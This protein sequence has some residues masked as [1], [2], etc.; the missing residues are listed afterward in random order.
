MEGD[1]HNVCNV[2]IELNRVGLLLGHGQSKF[3]IS[4]AKMSQKADNM[5]FLMFSGNF[6]VSTYPENKYA[7]IF[8][9]TQNLIAYV[10]L[11][12]SYKGTAHSLPMIHSYRIF[13][14]D[15]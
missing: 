1:L 5:C 7:Q 8:R 12:D 6:L 2:S 10:E 11:N 13:T 15:F 3:V 14:A 4:A 9:I